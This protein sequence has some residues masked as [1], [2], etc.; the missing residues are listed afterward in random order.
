MKKVVLTFGLISGVIIAIL[1]WLNSSLIAGGQIN[2]DRAELVGY[3]GFWVGG[4]ALY[5]WRIRSGREQ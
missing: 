2:W 3:F 4:D 5:Y 1:V